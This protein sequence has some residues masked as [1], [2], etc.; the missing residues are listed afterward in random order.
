MQFN[1]CCLVTRPLDERLDE[2]LDS[3]CRFVRVTES[4]QDVATTLIC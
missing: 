1:S 4:V 3:D 2:P